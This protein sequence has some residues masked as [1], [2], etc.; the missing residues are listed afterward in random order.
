M[1]NGTVRHV[2]R[3]DSKLTAEHIQPLVWISH[4][5]TFITSLLRHRHYPSVTVQWPESSEIKI[6]ESLRW[7]PL[8]MPRPVLIYNPP[9]CIWILCCDIT[10]Q[11]TVLKR[12]N[13]QQTI[14]E[15][16]KNFRH[17]ILKITCWQ[18]LILKHYDLRVGILN[19]TFLASISSLRP[20]K[21]LS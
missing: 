7:R 6:P 14:I 19:R 10:W 9:S 12:F 21:A 4:R 20:S 2:I 3:N 5:E 11:L 15:I 16:N 13:K 17:L 18:Y 8:I 1:Y